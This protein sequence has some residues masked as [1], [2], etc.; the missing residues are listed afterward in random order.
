MVRAMA[1]G[2][3]AAFGTL[4]SGRQDRKNLEADRTVVEGMLQTGLTSFR[5]R[6]IAM[7]GNACQVIS[8]ELDPG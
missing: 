6:G 5:Y 4:L 2:I 8:S 7:V 3:S 1:P